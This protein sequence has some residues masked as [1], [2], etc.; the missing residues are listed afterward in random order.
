MIKSD[1]VKNEFQLYGR[2]AT[3]GYDWW[4]HSFTAI[5][6][7][8]GEEKPFFVEYFFCNPL[9]EGIVKPV[10]GQHPDNQAVG[11]KPSYMMVKCGA[12]GDGAVQLHRFFPWKDVTIQP[13]APFSVKADDCF[14]TEDHM[15]G[16]VDVS[17]EDAEAHPE[18]MSDAGTMSWEL[19]IYK[20]L[21]WNH[22]PVADMFRK[23]RGLDMC[24]HVEGMKTKYKGWIL[25]NG[26]KYRVEP[27]TCYGYADKNWGSDFTTPWVWL[28]SNDIVSNISGK[29][30]SNSAFVIGGG[31]PVAFGI[32]MDSHLL[33]CLYYEGKDYEFSFTNVTSNI[34]TIFDGYETEDEVIVEV[35]QITRTN[36]MELEARCDKKDLQ[37]FRYEA[38]S[39]KA[40][41]T[42][43]WN[44][45]PAKA[46]LKL[47]GKGAKRGDWVLI[48]DL[49]L[50]HMG[51]EY[52][53][54]DKTTPYI[55]G[56][57]A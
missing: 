2:F 6:E 53:E 30:L 47:Y 21:T 46:N 29:R 27:E 54:Y 40:R 50:G 18:W 19:E 15:Y 31:R 17:A 36:K 42:R 45:G 1:L 13:K 49:A 24:W 57:K 37:F 11:R 32:P 41:H 22:G 52:G 3:E 55:K 7:E 4:W 23:L 35:T 51:F 43:L 5:N 33:S 10:L 8:T 34:K 20:C 28:N 12:W 44:G 56:E 26:Q 16:S 9:G 48:D 39:G 25:F 38:P 14:C